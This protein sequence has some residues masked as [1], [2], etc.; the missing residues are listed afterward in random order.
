MKKI[1][2]LLTIMLMI[3]T[4]IGGCG[5]LKTPEEL[6]QPPELNIEKKKLNDALLNYLPQ[7]ADLIVLPYVKGMKQES[8]LINKDIDGDGEKEAVALYRDKNTRKIGLIVMDKENDTW[9]RKTDIKLD[10]F[11]VADYKVI[12]TNNDG[13]DEIIIGYY[14]ITNPYKEVNI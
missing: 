8:S 6:I 5:V 4:V 7:N 3:T 13:L 10:V 14:G 12:D 11:E 1:F 9:M 2:T